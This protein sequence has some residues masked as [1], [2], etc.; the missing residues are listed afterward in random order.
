MRAAAERCQALVLG[1][2]GCGAFGND[3]VKVSA[4]FYKALYEERLAFFF[5]EIVFAVLDHSDDQRNYNAFASRFA[6][7]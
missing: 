6:E 3:P 7:V 2:W 1:A 4:L 5:K